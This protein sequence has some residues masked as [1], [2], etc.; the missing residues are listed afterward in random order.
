[1]FTGL[2]VRSRLF[3][4]PFQSA[5]DGTLRVRMRLTQQLGDILVSLTKTVIVIA[6]RLSTVRNA[7]N[8]LVL[9]NGAVSES[10]T[11]NELMAHDGLYRRL[12]DAQ[13]DHI[14]L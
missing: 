14:T 4:P 8:I 13:R 7:D 1:M 9:E 10:G 2:N 6:H 11:H 12:C 5:A 3:P